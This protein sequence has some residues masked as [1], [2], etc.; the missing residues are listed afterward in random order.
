MWPVQRSA[1]CDSKTYPVHI[2]DPLTPLPL[3]CLQAVFHPILRL[4]FF[5]QG[6]TGYGSQAPYC[7]SKGALIPLAK[8]LALAW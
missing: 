6:L 1:I 8:S 7:S 4:P 2:P 3:L 5:L